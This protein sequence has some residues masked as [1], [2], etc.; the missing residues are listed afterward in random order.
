MA[1]Q[2]TFALSMAVGN[3]G[4]LVAFYGRDRKVRIFD[5]RSGKLLQTIDDS[6]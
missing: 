5:F 3:K 4:E 6:L 1:K 2:K